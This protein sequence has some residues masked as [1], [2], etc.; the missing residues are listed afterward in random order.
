M[1]FNIPFGR[2][3]TVRTRLWQLILLQHKDGHWEAN[4]STAHALQALDGD[5][6]ADGQACPLSCS[7][8]VLEASLP[9]TLEAAGGRA[10]ALNIWAR[11]RTPPPPPP[12]LAGS[13]MRMRSIRAFSFPR[14]ALPFFR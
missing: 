4:S 3:W 1:P 6:V 9:P 5:A 10:A 13:R 12:A 14:L 7:V 8:E 11:R 2:Q